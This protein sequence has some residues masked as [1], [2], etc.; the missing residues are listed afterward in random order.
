MRTQTATGRFQYTCVRASG[1]GP[2]STLRI[3]R[4]GAGQA[5]EPT[6]QWR[7]M[8]RH[9]VAPVRWSSMCSSHG[10]PKRKGFGSKRLDYCAAAENDSYLYPELREKEL[11]EPN[12][13]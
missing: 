3:N 2:S 6:A 1:T 9:V 13:D 8:R 11:L 7:E 4:I 10:V 12:R 5:A